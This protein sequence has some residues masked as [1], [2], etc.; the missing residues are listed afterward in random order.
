M[1]SRKQGGRPQNDAEAVFDRLFGHTEGWKAGVAAA[2]E[3]AVVA[4]EVYALRQRHGLTQAELA[5]RCGSSQP[6]IARL[7]NAEYRGHSISVLRRIAAAVGERVCVR[8]MA[9]PIAVA[10]TTPTGSPAPAAPS[11]ACP[12][13]TRPTPRPTSRTRA[14]HASR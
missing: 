12:A 6:A 13:P 7:E 4:E 10:T 8:F 3:A 5:A 2:T 9:D 1:A 11:A 14:P